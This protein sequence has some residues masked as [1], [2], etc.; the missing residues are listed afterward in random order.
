MEK[1]RF[2]EAFRG[3]LNKNSNY[4]GFRITDV[5]ISEVL[6]YLVS[7]LGH[8]KSVLNAFIYF[9]PEN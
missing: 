9:S 4:G 1:F 7:C 6:L 2:V 8:Q 3:D 5:R